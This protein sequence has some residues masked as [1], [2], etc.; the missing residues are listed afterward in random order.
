MNSWYYSGTKKLNNTYF[1]ANIGKSVHE[2]PYKIVESK[3]FSSKITREGGR[4][5]GSGRVATLLD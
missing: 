3:S 4:T 1:Q 2:K 5:V